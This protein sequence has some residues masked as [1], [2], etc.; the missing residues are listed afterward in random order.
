MTGF[1]PLASNALAS[2]GD[3]GG[4]NLAPGQ[5]LVSGQNISII[6]SFEISLNSGGYAVIGH[7]VGLSRV[8][9][10]TEAIYGRKPVVIVELIQPRC[11][12]RFGTAPCTA[13]GTPKCFQ[14]YWTCLSKANYNTSGSITWRFTRAGDE[15]GWLYD[16]DND[17]TIRTN[18]L[19]LL[20]S[21]T[22]TSSRINP[23]AARSGE[24][25]LGRRATATITLNNGV[26]DDHVGDFYLGDRPARARPV[27]FWD[28]FVARNPFYPDFMVKIYEGYEGQALSQMQQRLYDLEKID[29]PSASDQYTLMCRDPLDR[30]RGKN[31]KYPPISSIDLRENI[32]AA[33]TSIPVACLTSQLSANYG[34]TGSTRYVVIG[35]EV[36][37]YTGWTGTEP[38]LTLT[39][40][41]RGVLNSTAEAH[42]A[43]DAV[44]RGA[45]HVDQRLY[46]VAKYILEDHTTVPNS[47]IDGAQWDAEGNAYLSTLQCDTFIGEPVAV[48]DLLGE[49]SRDGLFY[50]WWDE[51]A[52]KIPL[53]AVRPPKEVPVRLT[54]SDNIASFSKMQKIDDRMTRVTVFF[55]IRDWLEPLNEDR[56]YFN[57]RIRVDNEVE[58][59]AAA[60]GKIVENVIYS[61]WTN[62]F[63]NALLVSFSLLSRYRLPP[64][65]ATIEL[66]AK[67]RSIAVGDV[68]DLVTRYLQDTE[69]TPVETRWQVIGVDDP[70]PGTRIRVELQSYQFRGK[71]AVIMENDAPDY[72]DVSQEDRLTGCWLAVDA[73]GLMPDGTE[74]YLLQ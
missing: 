24:S 66:D 70:K 40:V 29:G 1:S 36:I 38:N 74:P 4:I 51:R 9:T 31:A 34:N 54:D 14:T 49:L 21:A 35:D 63:G 44:Q 53:L 5:F 50:I 16:Q 22:H 57:R 58:T 73:T 15:V 61:R 56:N 59:V 55:G 43:N 30:V 67:D 8:R 45:R 10:I 17:N 12:N 28:L 25:P 62:T 69:G 64:Q 33:T 19:P 52:Q 37:S 71:F 18:S 27:G 13:S 39:G 32:D 6:A 68:V 47:Y 7:P 26:W 60:G 46:Q 3:D 42:E 48:E 11:S 72:A 20:V 2:S 65:Y 41:T 23:G